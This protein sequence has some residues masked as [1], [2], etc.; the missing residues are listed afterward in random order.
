MAL[1][2]GTH[3]YFEIY[4]W[5]NPEKGTEVMKKRFHLPIVFRR[6]NPVLVLELSL[7]QLVKVFSR[8]PVLLHE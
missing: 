3:Q 5:N 8:L 7:S 2:A 1:V 4:S 6:A